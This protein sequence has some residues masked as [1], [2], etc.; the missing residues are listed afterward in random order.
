[1]TA[2]LLWCRAYA[3]GRRG[4]RLLELL[5]RA[6][7]KPPVAEAERLSFWAANIIP[8]EDRDRLHCLGLS[9]T[10]QRITYQKS[11]LEQAVNCPTCTVI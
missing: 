7:D 2:S 6:G 4:G 3:R 10:A 9:N 11:P 8:M 5:H 1:M